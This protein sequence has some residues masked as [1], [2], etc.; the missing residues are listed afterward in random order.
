MF[1]VHIGIAS[2]TTHVTEKY[3]KRYNLYVY[4]SSPP[5]LKILICQPLTRAGSSISGKGY[6]CIIEWEARLA[7]LETKLFN[8]HGIFKNDGRG[9]GSSEPPRTPSESATRHRI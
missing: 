3:G 8:L 1:L 9:G 4:P 7:D 6:I 5:L 2:M